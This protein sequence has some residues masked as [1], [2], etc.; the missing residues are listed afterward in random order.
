MSFGATAAWITFASAVVGAGTAIYSGQQQKKAL[1]YNASVARNQAEVEQQEAQEAIRRK[2]EE[3]KA[4]LSRQ[5]AVTA[6]QG[7]SIESGSS[8]LV[9]A[10]SAARLELGAL[11]MS[12]EGRNREQALLSR[13][14]QLKA[15]GRSVETAS[16][17]Q[18]GSSLLSGASSAYGAYN[19]NKIG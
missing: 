6:K 2:R 10:E 16:L 1:N 4:F 18:A 19:T 17:M 5:L 15:Q 8:L 7:G 3:N 12:R 9:A 11:E 14:R 13:S